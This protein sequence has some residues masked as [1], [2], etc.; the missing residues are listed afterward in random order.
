MITTIKCY[1]E[2]RRKLKLLAALLGMSMMDVLEDVIDKALKEAQK[3]QGA[4]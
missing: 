4:Q 1:V 3:Q 2:T